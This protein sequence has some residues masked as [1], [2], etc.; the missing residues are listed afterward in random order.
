M[1]NRNDLNDFKFISVKFKHYKNDRY[2]IIKR[3]WEY[4]YISIMM[5][6]ISKIIF[7][8]FITEYADKKPFLHHL[9]GAML[10]F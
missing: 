8:Y 3:F 7:L 2:K 9:K 6:D 4:A 5:G 1:H 10:K